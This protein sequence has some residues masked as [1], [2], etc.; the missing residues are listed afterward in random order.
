MP[1]TR[2]EERRIG[3]QPVQ[4]DVEGIEIVDGHRHVSRTDHQP[5]TTLACTHAASRCFTKRSAQASRSTSFPKIVRNSTAALNSSIGH[6]RFR[7]PIS[8]AITTLNGNG[9]LLNGRAT[10]SGGINDELPGPH[11]VRPPDAVHGTVPEVA[12]PPT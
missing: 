2:M 6:H 7:G 9:L 3:G 1:A 4:R 10:P 12:V 8:L 5:P 11:G